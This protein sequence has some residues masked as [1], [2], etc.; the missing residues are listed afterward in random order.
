MARGSQLVRQWNLLL[1]LQTRGDG[2]PLRELA[3]RFDVSE[4][5]IQRDFETLQELGFPIEHEADEQ[6]KRFWRMPHDFFR[7]GPFVISL[8]E[9]ISLHLAEEFLCPLAGTHLAE[10]LDTLL[11][12]IRKIL[13]DPAMRHFARLDE[14]LIVRRTGKTNYAAKAHIVRVLELCARERLTVEISYHALW[15]GE[16]YATR[17]DPYG[18]VFYEGDLFLVGRSHRADAL[19]VFK[20]ARIHEANHTNDRFDRPDEFDLEAHFRTSFGIVRSQ[21]D[22]IEIAVRF[23]GTGAALVGERKW[24]ESQRLYEPDEVSATLFEIQSPETDT[25]I[26]TFRL[27]DVTEF[28]RWILGFGCAAEILR[29]DWLRSE[30]AT[31]LAAAARRYAPP[32]ASA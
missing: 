10:G 7:Q 20:V 31:E 21:G 23:T 6:G 15:R 13:P 19:R 27:S 14:I 5:T 16:Q 29:P 11:A 24:H 3:D 28:K 9:A 26:A 25:L 1:A 4:R 30:M 2:I 18:L 22:A 12:K 8:T 32:G 17:V